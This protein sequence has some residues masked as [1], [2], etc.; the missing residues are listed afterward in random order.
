MCRMLNTLLTEIEKH[1]GIV[2]LATN[3]PYE[4]DEAMHRRINCVVEFRAPDLLMRRMILS[5]LLGLP[6]KSEEVEVEKKSG[7]VR[8]QLGIRISSDVDIDAIAVKYDLTGGFIKNAV[9][10]ALLSAM[11]RS[12]TDPI[13]CQ[14][15]LTL[16]CRLQMRGN[17]TLKAFDNRIVPSHGLDHLELTPSMRKAFDGIVQFEKTRGC[18]Y[19]SWSG[20]LNGCESRTGQAPIG[21]EQRACINVFAGPRG[22][23]K[24]TVLKS[25]GFELGRNVKLVH[26]LDLLSH[27]S[28]SESLSQ[29][30][31]LLNDAR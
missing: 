20:S 5:N 13:V 25:I 11:A 12:P 18:V 3:R 1:E 26:L 19:G 7:S 8:G 15:D 21:I 6:R 29:L 30:E 16:G 28:A 14:A 31:G 22:C 23:G 2:F 27:T 24:K 17:L 9:I 4:L 10:S